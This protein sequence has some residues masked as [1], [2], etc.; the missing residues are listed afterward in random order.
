MADQAVPLR[1]RHGV[2]YDPLFGYRAVREVDGVREHLGP[3]TTEARAQA[4]ADE[5]TM[6]MHAA[7]DQHGVPRTSGDTPLNLWTPEVRS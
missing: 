7:L 3:W 4:I 2:R 6:A 5:A 1:V